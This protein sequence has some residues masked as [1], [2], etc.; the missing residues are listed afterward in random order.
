MESAELSVSVDAAGNIIGRRE[1]SVRGARPLVF[2]SHADTVP[3]GG[4]YAACSASWVAS[5][6]RRFSRRIM[7][8]C[9]IRSR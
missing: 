2:G 9:I 3:R 5:N 1:G 8:G 6:W 4:N 7:S